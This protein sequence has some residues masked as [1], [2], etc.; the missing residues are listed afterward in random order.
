MQKKLWTILFVALSLIGLLLATG[1]LLANRDIP[2]DNPPAEPVLSPISADEPASAPTPETDLEAEPISD[3]EIVD[4]T[5]QS[6]PAYSFSD[7]WSIS[8]APPSDTWRGMTSA[9]TDPASVPPELKGHLLIFP[10]VRSYYTEESLVLW[11]GKVI[12]QGD[13]IPVTDFATGETVGFTMR[14]YLMDTDD[15]AEMYE[16]SEHCQIKYELFHPDGSFWYDTADLCITKVL[17]DYF[18]GGVDYNWD[19]PSYYT[20]DPSNPASRKDAPRIAHCGEDRCVIVARE[21]C[22]LFDG[23][24]FYVVDSG[25][26]IL[27]KYCPLPSYQCVNYFKNASGDDDVFLTWEKEGSKMIDLATLKEYRYL[28]GSQIDGGYR[29]FRTLDD[30]FEVWDMDGNVLV[31]NCDNDIIAYNKQFR[32]EQEPEYYRAYYGGKPIWKLPHDYEHEF[33]H[34]LLGESSFF[35]RD[36]E[37]NTLTHYDAEGEILESFQDAQFDY[38]GYLRI[39]N[40]YFLGDMFCAPEK[41]NYSYIKYLDYAFESYKNHNRFA[42]STANSNRSGSSYDFLD[43]NGHVLRSGFSRIESTNYPGIYSAQRGLV[44]GLIDKDGNWIWSEYVF[45]ENDDDI[46]YHGN[47]ETK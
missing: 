15:P 36:S 40:Q 17:G 18:F 1:F 32:I 43:E 33:F 34:F 16:F 10:D 8:S 35:V 22:E 20:T 42:G 37:S 9:M 46:Y 28:C 41:D 44:H 14:S 45:S 4:D 29:V 38:F 3:P 39:D 7:N 11:D 5:P 24:G 21:N 13:A 27:A 31:D 19:Y 30:K 25:L 26:N 23:S 2:E 12:A 6:P 47:K